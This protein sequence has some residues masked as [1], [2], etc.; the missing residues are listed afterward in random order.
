MDCVFCKIVAGELP[1]YKIYEDDL[2]LA[3]LD[4]NPINIGHTL[5]IPKKHY[6]STLETP[7]ELIKHI[8][9]IVKRLAQAI[10]IATEA[11]GCNIG[12]NNGEASGQIV[13]H[14]H[15]HIMPRFKNDGYQL[16][17]GDDTTYNHGEA[18]DIA[19]KIKVEL[20]NIEI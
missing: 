8:A 20:N 13:F 14:T 17:Q 6:H 7:D 4:I 3:F 16:W 12:I 5:I 19:E 10:V 1:S 11:D 9:V 15:W 18:D 2:V